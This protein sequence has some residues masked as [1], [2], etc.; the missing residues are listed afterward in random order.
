M[1]RSLLIA[2]SCSLALA[3]PAAAQEA[4][5]TI[6][7]QDRLALKV[8]EWLPARG[9]YKEWTA[10]G[11]EYAIAPGDTINVPF[12]GQVSTAGQ[13]TAEVARAVA[14]RLQRNLSLPLRPEV[15]IE[16]VGRSPVYVLGGVETP[17]KV[18]FTPGLTAIE[19]VALAGGFYRGGGGELRLER[20]AINAEGDLDA[21]RDNAARLAARVARLE[22]ELADGGGTIKLAAGTPDAGRVERFVPEEQ[23][24]L[25]IR[26][27]ARESQLESLRNRRQLAVD[28]LKSLDEKG[29]NLER[30]V[31]LAREQLGGVES[32]VDKGLTVASRRFE[33]E[34][35]LSD[36]EGRVLDVQNSRLAA[37]LE[38]NESE[39]QQA[40][41]VT[42]F[43]TDA[44]NDLQSGRA[45]LS[46]ARI[47]VGRG[48][49]LL[50]EA[51]V[52]APE[53]LMDR[54]GNFQVGIRFFRT[55]DEGGNRATAEIRKDDVLEAGDTLQ[56][57]MDTDAGREP[58]DRLSSSQ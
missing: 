4:R 46:R 20:D 32:L 29:T 39:R 50:R 41:V 18:D 14:D 11:G 55:R 54:A 44:A 15:G 13:T 45:A 17:G 27:Q 33:L 8:L 38:I 37:Q 24:L 1:T 16:I 9:E 22:T 25:E 28:Q 58:A 5:G 40:D 3:A 42:Q 57:Q 2:L 56:I 6:G 7:P 43:K 19:A 30:Q 23:H 51:T 53:K 12:A 26:R 52:I 10:V 34:R 49:Q 35:T 31:Q 36:F 48:E 21:A 47:D